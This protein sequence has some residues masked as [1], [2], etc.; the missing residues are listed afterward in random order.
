MSKRNIVIAVGAVALAIAWYAF[1]PELLFVDKTVNEE[2][3]GA[4][5][6]AASDKGPALLA[7]GTFKGL[8]HESQ[9]LASVYR[10]VDGKRVLRL[11]EFATSNGPDVHVYLTA[12]AVE[13]GNAAIKQAGFVDLGSMKG[14]KGNQNY[15]I[16]ANIDVNKFRNV[17]IWCARFGVNFAQATLDGPALSP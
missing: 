17:A 1:R 12:A 7:K 16:P 2:S 14:N 11:T 8:A 9:G 13:K 10:L 6:I 4:S 15:E 3:P 5:T